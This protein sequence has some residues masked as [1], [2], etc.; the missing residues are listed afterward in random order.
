MKS[1]TRIQPLHIWL[2]TGPENPFYR[3]LRGYG[4]HGHGQVAQVAT[5]PVL[6]VHNTEYVGVR[7]DGTDF[8]APVAG[9]PGV[10]VFTLAAM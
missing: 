2:A 10:W 9:V 4:F 8:V 6:Y 1:T 7:S 5:S 3:G